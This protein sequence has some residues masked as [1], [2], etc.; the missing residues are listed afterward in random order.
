MQAS[1]ATVPAHTEEPNEDFA[2]VG[3]AAA[4]LLDGAGLPE[5]VASGCSHGAA[6]FARNLGGALL[7]SISG[8]GGGSLADGLAESIRRVRSLHDGTCDLTHE[9]TPSATVVAVRLRKLVLEYLVLA[10][11]V[12]LVQRPNDDPLV[13]CDDREMSTGRPYRAALDAAP[14]GT[15]AYKTALQ[16]YKESVRDRRNR[17]GGFWVA[18]A[19]PAAAM[20]ALTGEIPLEDIESVTLLSDGASRLV[21]KFDLATWSDLVKIITEDGPGQLIRWTRAA[22]DSDPDGRRW[23]RGKARDDATAMFCRDLAPA[24]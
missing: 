19:D 2:A 11:S 20:Q 6:W 17:P 1:I 24:I 22:E 3:P 18:S 16:E 4:V 8:P 15:A 10:D 14:I 23:P 9:G 21:D 7:A 12:L 13:A 5:G